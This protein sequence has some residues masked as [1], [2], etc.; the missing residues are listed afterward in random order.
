MVEGAGTDHGLSARSYLG[1][2]RAYRSRCRIA[3]AAGVAVAVAWVGMFGRFAARERWRVATGVDSLRSGRSGD[4]KGLCGAAGQ[5]ASDPDGNCFR[6]RGLGD[7]SPLAELRLRA[8]SLVDRKA[9]GLSERLV[10]RCRHG[11]LGRSPLAVVAERFG[12]IRRREQLVPWIVHLVALVF[13]GGDWMPGLRL[14]APLFPWLAWQIAP[15]LTKAWHLAALLGCA[16]FPLML[17]AQQGADLR[18]VSE[19]RLALIEAARPAL[20]G[21]EVIAGVDIGWLGVATDAQIVDLAGVTDPKVAALPGGHTSKAVYSGLFSGRNVDAWV[22]RTSDASYQAGD[23][24]ESIQAS[25]WVDGRL[26]N[27]SENLGMKL[28]AFIPLQGTAGGY[29]I[30]RLA[31]SDRCQT[32]RRN[33]P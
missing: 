24:V 23:P 22:V 18:A 19:R 17:L 12:G 14:S 33:H 26:L 25:Y 21:A 9:A 7:D 11:S 4:A 13:A 6:A 1:W 5:A 31:Q 32:M 20:V 27:R 28:C 3:V 16:I 29:V 15:R 30:L 2:C 8:A 10:L